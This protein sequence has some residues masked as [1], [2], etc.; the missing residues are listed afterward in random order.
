MTTR[1]LIRR[2]ALALAATS[3]FA[4][5]SAAPA[6]AAPTDVNAARACSTPKYPGSGYFT[7]LRVSGTSCSTG[8]RVARAHYSCRRK[9]GVRGRCGR[10]VLRFRCSE[11][12]P[13]SGRTRNEYNARVSCRRGGRRVVFTYQQ[14]T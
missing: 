7:S 14:N 10:R 12:R 11:S 1:S 4:A 9:N 6:M 8:R 3:C 2:G 13:S 5:A